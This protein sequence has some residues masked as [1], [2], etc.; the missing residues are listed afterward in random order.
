MLQPFM[1]VTVE[2]LHLTKRFGPTP[3]LD[4][5]SLAVEQGRLT[6]LLGPSGCGKTTLLR[7]I[8][9]FDQPDGGQILLNSRPVAG[10]G[11]V[12]PPEQRRVGMVF[13]EYALFQHLNVGENIAFGLQGN[14]RQKHIRVQEML[15]LVGLQ[16]YAARMPHELSGGQQQRVALARAL[17]PQPDVLLLD[18]PFSNLDTALRAQVRSEVRA[19][20]KRT[21]ATCLF[22]THDQEE[23]LS[24]ADEVAVMLEGRILQVAPPQTLYHEPVNRA[25]AAFVGESN[26]LGGEA[27]GDVVDC[28]LGILPLQKRLTGPVDILIRPEALH[29]GPASNGGIHARVTWREF[30]GHDQRLGVELENGQP[31]IVRLGP[32][33]TF[34]VG[35]RVAVNVTRPVI[36]YPADLQD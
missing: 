22:V 14:R 26:F 20:L 15:D 28:V 16:G 6:A 23:A 10:A 8:A 35:E 31:L 30:Y 27:R 25:V 13:Q 5:V 29:L 24:L 36:A 19:I 11:V 12:V 34:D 1:P 17:A 3:A 2:C 4:D 21:R 7:L 33:E 32:G 18:E 9:G